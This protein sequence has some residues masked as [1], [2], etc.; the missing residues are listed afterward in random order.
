[1]TTP[2]DADRTSDEQ[3]LVRIQDGERDLFGTLVRR[4]ERELYGYL[5]RY[6]GDADLAADVFQNTW[7][8]VYV[9]IAQYQPGRPARPWLY[10]VATNQA[11][12]AL[13]RRSRRADSRT[14][15]LVAGDAGSDARPGFEL[16]ADPGAGP[17]EHAE[18][19][20]TRQRVRDAVDKL[21]GVMRQVVILAYFQGLR[22]QEIA[23]IM[24]IPLGTVKSRLHAAL[25][26][27]TE[28]WD[29]VPEA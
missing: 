27:L 13:R 29:G 5:R 14:D 22:Y 20:E 21:P 18:T 23:D 25:A 1:M 10:A 6:L 19:A 28:I 4:Y 26:K 9:K 17:T 2:H 24:D 11:I 8:Q 7:T 12:D 3:L 15:P 16:L